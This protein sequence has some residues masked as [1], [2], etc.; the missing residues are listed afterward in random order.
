MIC[1]LATI[2]SFINAAPIRCRSIETLSPILLRSLVLKSNL[3]R[4]RLVLVRVCSF[5]IG[6]VC[7]ST[8]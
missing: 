5:G 3:L 1:K 8:G 6:K 4:I 7:G 2:C